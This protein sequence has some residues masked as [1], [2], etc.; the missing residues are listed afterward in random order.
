MMDRRLRGDGTLFKRSDGYWVGGVE[1][2]PG[3]DGKRRVKRVVAKNR[4][5]V[6]EKL[7]KLK[8]DVAAGAVPTGPSITVEKWFTYWITDILPHTKTVPSTRKQYKDSVRLY[9]L[10]T[11]GAKKLDKLT[12]ADIRGLYTH[13][14]KT[15]SS[16]AALK[17]HQVLNLGIKAAIREEVLIANVLNRVDKPGHVVAEQDVFDLTAALHIIDTAQ[18][19]QGPMWAA[20]W[21]LG[22]T[23]GARESEILG[24]EWSR[25]HLDKAYIDNSWQLLRMQQ[26]HGCGK[27]DGDTYPCK[28]KRSSFCPQAQWDFP[29]GMQWRPCTNTLVW[30]RPKTKAGTRLIPLLP[31]MITLLQALPDG[32]NPHNLVFHHD[33]GAPF[34]QDQ[35]QAMWRQLLRDAHI[36]HIR[37]H[38]IRRSTATLLME[39]GVDVHIIQSVIGHSNITMTRAY[40]HVNLEL[41]RRAW[42]SLSPVLPQL[43]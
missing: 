18:K 16:R 37:Q 22:F 40:Q 5:T 35:D 13:L 4:N 21:A 23:T 41:A 24:L 32:P 17:A 6:L 36:S 43:G 12:P 14:Q 11:L 2:P 31:G 28:K 34:T 39:A 33:D 8:K 27:P 20:R 19:T 9:V 38:S 26:E 1:L 25:V 30:T 15:V 7:R 10:P 42:Q 3:P 29:P